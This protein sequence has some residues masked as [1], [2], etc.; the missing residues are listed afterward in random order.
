MALN[1]YPI[2]IPLNH[3]IRRILEEIRDGW[4]EIPELD[5]RD[6]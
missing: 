4:V 1:F 6:F 5:I 2:F 3:F